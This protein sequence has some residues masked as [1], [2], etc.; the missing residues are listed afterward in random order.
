MNI[1][2]SHGTSIVDAAQE[3]IEAAA[4]HNADVTFDF[5]GINIHLNKDS[6][7]DDVSDRYNALNDERRKVYLASP[8]GIQA[9]KERMGY[10]SF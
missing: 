1:V 4:K 6:L 7:P 10:W 9:A 5:N 2:F 8:K 3:A